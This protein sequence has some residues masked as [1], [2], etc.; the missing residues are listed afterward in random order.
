MENII[1]KATPSFP[2]VVSLAKSVLFFGHSH[3]H[4]AIT[5]RF[6]KKLIKEVGDRSFKE[7]FSI[8]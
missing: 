3:H 7:V 2:K 5:V 4:K 6:S 8:L 1:L